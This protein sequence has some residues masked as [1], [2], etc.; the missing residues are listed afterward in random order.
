M[1]KD[2]LLQTLQDFQQEFR[3]FRNEAKEEF[4]SIKKDV[5]DLKK[6]TILV[7]KDVNELK[8]DVGNLKSGMF[9]VK[10]TLSSHTLSLLNIENTNKIYR[11]MFQINKQGIGEL[12]IRVS[13]LESR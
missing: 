11:D 4:K 5:S 6:D 12:N 8:K 7:K 10:K 9:G 2:K 1:I 13:T 3:D